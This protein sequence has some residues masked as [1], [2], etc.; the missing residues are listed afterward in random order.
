MK[1]SRL[2]K[3]EN[4]LEV[5]VF[6]ELPEHI[7][8]L[9]RLSTKAKLDLKWSPS[10]SLQSPWNSP[11]PKKNNETPRTWSDRPRRASGAP[12]CSGRGAGTRWRPAGG[13]GASS[14]TA[15]SWRRCAGCCSFWVGAAATRGRRSAGAPCRWRSGRSGTGP[16]TART[17]TCPQRRRHSVIHQFEDCSV[18]ET[19]SPE[20]VHV[21]AQLLPVAVVRKEV[22]Q[23]FQVLQ[24]LL[25]HSR[26]RLKQQQK[27]KWRFNR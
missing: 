4:R 8:Q 18:P 23:P 16:G 27:P 1:I 26:P 3:I 2:Q 12:R 15:G 24:L 20:G 22:G 21:L 7:G 25:G 17:A 14:R 11:P 9:Q 13:S 6:D 10:T 19:Q 5:V